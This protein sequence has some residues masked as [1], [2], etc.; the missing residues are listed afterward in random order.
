MQGIGNK[1]DTVNIDGNRKNGSDIPLP[2]MYK[3]YKQNARQLSCEEYVKEI[4]IACAHGLGCTEIFFIGSNGKEQESN[5]GHTAED[6]SEQNAV[7]RLSPANSRTATNTYIDTL[8]TQQHP[9]V[10]KSEGPEYPVQRII[11]SARQ[12]GHSTCT[13]CSDRE[14]PGSS[15]LKS[16]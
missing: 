2:D 10:N 6:A 13:G 7:M 14:L 12:N 8:R 15:S 1:H 9:T 11:C 3:I 4:Q 16:G 5:N